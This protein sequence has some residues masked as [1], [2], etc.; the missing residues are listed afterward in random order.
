MRVFDEYSNADLN[1]LDLSALCAIFTTLVLCLLNVGQSFVH[2]IQSSQPL[3][4][5]AIILFL[6]ADIGTVYLFFRMLYHCVSNRD[7][8]LLV[9]IVLIPLFLWLAWIVALFY[10]FLVYRRKARSVYRERLRAGGSSLTLP[11]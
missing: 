3:Y 4:A 7:L 5:I 2:R 1:T 9:R 6:I 8:P 11:Q 10:Y